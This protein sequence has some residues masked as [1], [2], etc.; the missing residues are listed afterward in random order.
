[1]KYSDEMPRERFDMQLGPGQK[2]D[3]QATWT[4]AIEKR[5]PNIF[6]TI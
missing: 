2:V 6:L 5:R 1:M 4:Q 3:N